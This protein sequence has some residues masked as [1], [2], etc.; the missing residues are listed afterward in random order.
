MTPSLLCARIRMI[1]DHPNPHSVLTSVTADI[2]G[3][4][5]FT[6]LQLVVEQRLRWQ[7]SIAHVYMYG[8]MA[9]NYTVF[10]IFMQCFSPVKAYII[11]K[12]VAYLR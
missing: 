4:N 9:V 10:P 8:R 12:I 1:R 5:Y 2:V 11:S 6:A 3:G 7:Q